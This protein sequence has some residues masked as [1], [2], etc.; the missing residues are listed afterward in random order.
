MF[1]ALPPGLKN[2]GFTRKRMRKYRQQGF[3]AYVFVVIAMLSIVAIAASKMSLGGGQAQWKFET[4]KALLDQSNIIR[5]RVIA[6][7]I[8]YPSGDNG[9]GF[10]PRFPATPTSG[11]VVDMVCPGQPAP[12]NLWTGV[13]GMSL[14]ASPGGFSGWK[15]TN[16][17][18]NIRIS[19]QANVGISDIG[20]NAILDT[21]RARIGA[22]A[23]RSGAVLTI[24]LMV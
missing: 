15:Y 4:R 8:S 21:I 12:N 22:N 23:S 9:S 16:D 2:R 5:S 10:H 11:L 6:C 19:I 13:G 1:Q 7:G 24:I 18:A 14:R 20:A 3:V 17:G